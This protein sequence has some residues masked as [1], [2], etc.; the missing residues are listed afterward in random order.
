MTG[1]SWCQYSAFA[2]AETVTS[3]TTI[4]IYVAALQHLMKRP[5]IIK[6]YCPYCGQHT[7]HDLKRVKKKKASEFKQGQRRFRRV[8]AGYRG[9]PRPKPQGDKPTK[10]IHLKYTCKE[11]GKAHQ[12]KGIRA[13]QF[14]F[15]R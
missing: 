3:E 14:E 11:C 13:K 12:K 2:G 10:R 4:F 9:Y 8:T 15:E 1:F 5:S 6:T 7:E